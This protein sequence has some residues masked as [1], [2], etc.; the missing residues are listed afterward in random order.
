MFLASDSP[1]DL[2]GRV[3]QEVT[4]DLSILSQ[5]MPG[6]MAWDARTLR[7]LGTS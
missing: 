7:L 3:I 4:E 2:N 1:E 6:I 5:R